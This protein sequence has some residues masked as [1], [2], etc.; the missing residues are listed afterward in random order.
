MTLESL[1]GTTPVIP[2]LVIDRLDQAV[3]LGRALVESGLPVLEVT[4]RTPAALEAISALRA[5]L[6]AAV[7]AAGTVLTPAQARDAAA[8]GAQFLVS[9]GST[10]ALLDGIAPLNVP[11]LPGAATV[12][13]MMALQERGYRMVK[14]FPAQAAG[15]PDYLKGLLSPLPQLRFCPTGGIDGASARKW[16]ALPNVACVGGSW[17]ARPE[18]IAAGDWA[19]VREAAAEAAML[20]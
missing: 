16:L 13:E 5:A 7:V 6:P 4:L 14:F 12:S 9:P 11:L 1:I 18:W 20:R 3:P 19:P 8:A 10:P 17:M 2:V 15:G